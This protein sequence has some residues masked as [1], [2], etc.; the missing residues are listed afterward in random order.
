MG[1]EALCR[2]ASLVVGI[3]RSGRAC[4]VIRQNWQPLAQSDQSIQ[5]LKGDVVQRLPQL[6]GQQFD[7]IYFDPPYASG[8]YHPVL[9]AIAHCD[10]LD[11]AGE[12]AVEHSPSYELHSEIVSPNLASGVSAIL[13]CCRRKTYG[14]TALT[15]YRSRESIHSF[16]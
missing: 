11:Q 9:E 6:T 12:L 4:S 7:R 2:G 1:A 5:V 13:T 10:L 8:L 3:E 14:S 16:V 15:F